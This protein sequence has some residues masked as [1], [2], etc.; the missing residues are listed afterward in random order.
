MANL[1]PGQSLRPGQSL[2]SDNRLH[3]L[4]V[5]AD[6]NVVLHGRDSRPLWATN[7]SGTTPRE[8]I[9]QEDGNLVLY[10]TDGHARCASNTAK[11]PGASLHVQDDGNLVVYR[12]GARAETAD[13]A[14]W[15]AGS[16]DV[17][18]NGGGT[19]NP[20]GAGSIAAR[21]LEL[22][23]QQRKAAGL[24]ALVLNAQLMSA[25]QAHSQDMADHNFMAHNGS[26]GSSPFDRMRRAGYQYSA[27]AENVAAG[28][29]DPEGAM[30]SW[31]NERPPND[32][33]R[34]NLLNPELREIGIGHAFKDGTAYKHY[35]TQDFGRR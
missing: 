18:A 9:M 14:L 31:M 11:N 35:W 13:N 34:R 29:P 33:H 28:Q 8:F 21:M 20:G 19:E 5:Q 32:G 3:T 7:T 30:S 16:H 26:D 23:N 2:H 22:V 25:A 17:V 6:G 10:A 12:A 15:A 4:V 24:A 1:S 27:A